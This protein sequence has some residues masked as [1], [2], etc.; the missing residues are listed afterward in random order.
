MDGGLYQLSWGD[1]ER[2]SALLAQ[3]QSALESGEFTDVTLVTEDDQMFRAHRFVLAACSISFRNIFSASPA[4]SLHI[5]MYGLQHTNLMHLLD[6]MYT[7]M[8]SMPKDSLSS[9][10]QMAKDL[11]V[12]GLMNK[13]VDSVLCKTEESFKEMQNLNVLEETTVSQNNDETMEISPLTLTK[14]HINTDNTEKIHSC[15]KY[16]FTCD[17]HTSLKEHIHSTKNTLKDETQIKNDSDF[18]EHNEMMKGQIEQ[19]DKKKMFC[20]KCKKCYMTIV[21]FQKHKKNCRF[22]CTC[23]K[24]FAK[25]IDL[26]KH[27]S[28][29]HK[30]VKDIIDQ[31]IDHFKENIEKEYN[32]IFIDS[33]KVNSYPKEN[34]NVDSQMKSSNTDLY[35]CESC[36]TKW[37]TK[38]DLKNHYHNEH[39]SLI[40]NPSASFTCDLCINKGNNIVYNGLTE[41]KEHFVANHQN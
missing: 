1:G 39:Q 17:G 25:N 5:Y 24:T 14:S 31:Q 7:G 35:V 34:K 8:T 30:Y 36:D 21:Q 38:E 12:T 19:H 20:K 18:K 9:F 41:L 11:Q 26:Q 22:I 28:K 29:K 33:K 32:E 13:E 16:Q 23:G 2:T 27:N 6:F 10:I 40:F 15:A 4:N 3:C 37:Q